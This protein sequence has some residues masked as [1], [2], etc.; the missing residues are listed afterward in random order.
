MKKNALGLFLLMLSIFTSCSMFYMI[1]P[2][3]I[4]WSDYLGSLTSKIIW[5][6]D[7]IYFFRYKYTP[8]DKYNGEVSGLVLNILNPYTRE[9]RCDTVSLNS[10]NEKYQGIFTSIN[11]NSMLFQDSDILERNYILKFETGEIVPITDT[12]IYNEDML[13]ISPDSHYVYYR[14]KI[15][16]YNYDDDSTHV[17]QITDI[18][19]I[20]VNWNINKIAAM[21]QYE[22]HILD[23]NSKEEESVVVS[24]KLGTVRVRW[25]GD[26]I[27][28]S[29]NTEQYG[30][31]VAK[32]D[33]SCNIICY[34]NVDYFNMNDRG[35][36]IQYSSLYDTKIQLKLYNIKDELVDSFYF[37]SDGNLMKIEN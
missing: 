10:E 23:L 28:A 11:N 33:T 25:K 26:T 9:F 8:V 18:K 30:P 35:D 6:D 14:G 27:I 21:Q 5:H 15:N 7:N 34:D 4:D 22:L 2:E 16:Y 29:T 24:E 36:Y 17:F 31:A 20:A 3:Y 1:A 19:D 12:T 37:D 32:V 13:C